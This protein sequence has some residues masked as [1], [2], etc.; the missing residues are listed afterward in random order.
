MAKA[1]VEVMGAYVDGNAPGTTINV[2]EKSAKYL[3]SIGYVK[4]TEE[5]QKP[6]PEPKAEKKSTEKKTK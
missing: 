3:E 6:K 4:R 1:R 2:E 5:K